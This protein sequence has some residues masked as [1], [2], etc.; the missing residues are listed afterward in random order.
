M[1]NQKPRPDEQQQVYLATLLIAAM[2]SHQLTRPG[3]VL[4]FG[5]QVGVEVSPTAGYGLRFRCADQTLCSVAFFFV[6]SSVPQS[7]ARV[8]GFRALGRDV[9]G[10]P[11]SSSDRFTD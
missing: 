3:W 11:F 10:V 5:C 6:G 9:H 2:S 4:S 8:E 7:W 1:R